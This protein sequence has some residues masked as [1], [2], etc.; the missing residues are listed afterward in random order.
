MQAG[1]SLVISCVQRH[2]SIPDYVHRI[3]TDVE[4]HIPDP[5][6][7]LWQYKKLSIRSADLHPKGLLGDGL[8]DAEF[9]IKES[10]GIDANIMAMTADVP[11]D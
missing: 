4:N 7:R 8:D 5:N 11:P 2:Q 6:D 3:H 10:L 1:T 9:I